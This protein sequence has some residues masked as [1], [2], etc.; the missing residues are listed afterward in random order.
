[1][2][3][4]RALQA[5][6]KLD[7][8]SLMLAR[9]TRSVAGGM[10]NVAFPYYILTTLHYGALEMGVI[11]LCARIA[12]AVLGFLGGLAA[13]SLGK[14]NTLVAA[15]LFL[16]LGALIV[17]SSTSLWGIIP[18]AMIGG[19]SGAGLLGGGGGGAVQP[20]QSVVIAD[21]TSSEKRT[22]FF[23]VFSFVSG[24]AAA[25]GALLTKVLT[26]REVFL[27]ASIIS[28]LG[29]PA[30]LRLHVVNS[31]RKIRRLKTKATIG[32]FTLTGM[33]N[34]LS[35]GLVVP[36]LIP[37]FVL[38]YHIPM[39]QMSVYAFAGR[40]LG[41]AAILG[42]PALERK[43]GFVGSVVMTRGLGLLLFVLLP[44][45]KYFP[46][47]IAIYMLS[48]TL[49][50]AAAPIQRS[51]LTRQ[52][53]EDEMGRALGIN[54]VARLAASSTGTGL[55]GV[56]MQDALYDIPFFAYAVLMLGN[57]YLYVKLFGGK[58]PGA[59]SGGRKGREQNA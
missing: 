23:S 9:M 59:R 55:S 58:R 34:G 14:R 43:F 27:F 35:Q 18:G 53:H 32:K 50:V 41:S 19:F 8:P 36:F 48:P 44:I 47:S 4:L 42:A 1:M 40:I 38:V 21:L 26:A 29:I 6:G 16:P 49:R 37:F 52:V 7:I 11:F 3:Q 2:K 51:E 33:L 31:R 20:I 28:L 15:S 30:L 25:L 10:I 54:Q 22:R 39:S 17:F 56:L 24:L 13:D 45:V 5:Q 12:A 57:L 46:V